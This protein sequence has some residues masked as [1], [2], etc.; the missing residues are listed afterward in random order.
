MVAFVQCPRCADDLTA[1]LCEEF[2]NGLPD[3]TAR[4][5]DDNMFPIQFAHLSHLYLVSV[6]G[7]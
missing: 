5:R 6:R 4:A 1:F 3:A 2:G 7:E